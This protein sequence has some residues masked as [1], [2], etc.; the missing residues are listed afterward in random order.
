MVLAM[1]K[2]D[3]AKNL[4][5]LLK[6]QEIRTY[7]S[8]DVIGAQVGGAIKNVI[9]IGAGIVSGACLGH[10]ALAGLITRG[11][12]ELLIFSKLFGGKENTIFGLSGLGDLV[13]TC[14]SEN[15][16]N[17][18]LGQQIGQLGY[19]DKSLQNNLKGVSEG[20]YTAKA[21]HEII[22]KHNLNMPVCKEIYAICHE[23]KT[24]KEA[25]NNMMNRGLKQEF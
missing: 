20:F 24:L 6:T 23:G 12:Q 3:N 5:E 10:N 18:S 22:E 21:I 1:E 14:T 15:S 4:A 17:F 2:I 9:A 25:I 7:Y 16:R 19:Y 11:L 13:L 8:D